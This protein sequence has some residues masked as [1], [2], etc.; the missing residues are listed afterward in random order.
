MKTV[1]LVVAVVALGAVAAGRL[2]Q[3]APPVAAPVASTS[4]AVAN[5]AEAPIP[6]AE[7][8][9]RSDAQFARLAAQI[10]A[11]QAE[12]REVRHA[13]AA[14][15][16]DDAPEAPVP[17]DRRTE[18]LSDEE[19]IRR[20]RAQVEEAKAFYETLYEQEARD[21]GWAGEREREVRS[22]LSEKLSD[23]S[24]LDSIECRSTKCR[25]A[26]SVETPDDMQSLNRLWGRGPFRYGSFSSL[27]ASGRAMIVYVG[28]SE[29]T[30]EHPSF[31]S[32]N[33]P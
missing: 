3:D 17:D 7:G 26:L 16:E 32:S 31:R 25:I 13:Q 19:M 14:R 20:E 24:R 18:P 22:Y 4:D 9:A 11:L 12:L 10:R 1:L 6:R 27:D 23:A 15:D 28:R 8:D 30:F 21:A 2:M 33:A 29:H 5:R